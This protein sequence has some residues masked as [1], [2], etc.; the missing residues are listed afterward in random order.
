VPITIDQIVPGIDLATDAIV[1]V[2]ASLLL[3]E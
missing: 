3:T 2:P 1:S